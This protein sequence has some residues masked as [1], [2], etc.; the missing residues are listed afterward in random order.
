MHRIWNTQLDVKQRQMVQMPR[1]AQILSLV[2]KNEFPH[3]YYLVEMKDADLQGDTKILAGD[4]PVAS[5]IPTSP[6]VPRVFSVV[7]AGEAF[8]AES[9]VFIGTLPLGKGG[10][11]AHVFEHPAK[12]AKG[13]RPDDRYADDHQDLHR[14]R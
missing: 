12:G 5:K 14:V 10:Y 6:M 7:C 3:L 13:Y 1:D 2:E 11:I 8:E 4:Q 9:A